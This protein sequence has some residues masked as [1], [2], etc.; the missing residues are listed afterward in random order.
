MKAVWLFNQF[1]TQASLL[2]GVLLSDFPNDLGHPIVG[3]TGSFIFVFT[4]R[5]TSSVGAND[6]MSRDL[7]IPLR[8][9]DIL[10][11]FDKEK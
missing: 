4:C 7:P 10:H 2:V 5:P 9:F 3:A 11:R 8:L 1:S 6:F